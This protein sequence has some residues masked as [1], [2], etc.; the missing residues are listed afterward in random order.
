MDCDP[1]VDDSESNKNKSKDEIKSKRSD[2]L[3]EITPD[4]E[5][6]EVINSN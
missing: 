3:V 5:F 2:E 4:C 6:Y 1:L